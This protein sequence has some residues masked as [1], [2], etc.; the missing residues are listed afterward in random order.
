[1]SRKLISVIV[2]AIFMAIGWFIVELLG[3]KSL[4]KIFKKEEK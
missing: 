1:M 3:K 2:V 4:P